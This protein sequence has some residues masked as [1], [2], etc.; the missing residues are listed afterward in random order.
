LENPPVRLPVLAAVLTLTAA[1]AM[2]QSTAPFFVSESGKGFSRLSEAVDAIGD[3]EGTIL[4]APGTYADCAIQTAGRVA[5]VAR[6]PGTVTFDGGVCE[7][8]ATLVLRGRGAHVQGIRFTH[9]V[10]PDGNGAGIRLEQANLTVVGSTFIDAQCGILS[11]D[12]ASTNTVTVDRSTFAGLGKDPRGNGA[13]AMYI[14]RVRSLKVTNSRFERGTG[15]HYIKSRAPN[16]EVLDSSFDDSRGTMTN[17]MIDLPN[18]AIGRIAGNAFV[19]G[20]GKENRT[21][22]ISVAPEGRENTSA[23]L[24]IENNKAWLVPNYPWQT[25][26]VANWTS[27][28]VIERNNTLAPGIVRTKRM[29]DSG[30][31]QLLRMAYNFIHQKALGLL[32]A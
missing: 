8:K 6:Q 23:G 19:N 17:Y 20:L 14:G 24:V 31:R 5:F 15:G 11:G 9:Q 7:G 12:E 26:F 22:F 4:I 21:T 1:P 18:G 28:Q 30:A 16:I 29:A 3:G 2:A 13:H 25:A 27:D 32:S 10:V